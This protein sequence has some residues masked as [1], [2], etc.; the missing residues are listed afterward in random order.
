MPRC[1]NRAFAV[2]DPQS[3]LHVANSAGNWQWVAGTGSDTRPNRMLNPIRQRH[4][5]DPEGICAGRCLPELGT[6]EYPRRI[7]QEDAMARFRVAGAL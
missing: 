5:L 7:E 1:P 6:A 3:L 2:P 4:S